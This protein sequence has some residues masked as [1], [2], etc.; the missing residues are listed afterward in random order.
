MSQIDSS[1]LDTRQE[2]YLLPFYKEGWMDARAGME[3]KTQT[4]DLTYKV[5]LR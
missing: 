1:L 2:Q 3:T 5:G 4:F